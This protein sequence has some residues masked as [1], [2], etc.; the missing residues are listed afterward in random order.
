MF[1]IDYSKDRHAHDVIISVKDL[2]DI[3]TNKIDIFFIKWFHILI[4]LLLFLN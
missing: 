3:I 2:I 4:L 1:V